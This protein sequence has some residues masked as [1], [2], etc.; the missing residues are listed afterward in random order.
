MMAVGVFGIQDG[1]VPLPGLAEQISH[2]K[3]MIQEPHWHHGS[4][5]QQAKDH[6][7]RLRYHTRPSS[8]V[9]ACVWFGARGSGLF[10][11]IEVIEKGWCTP[12]TDSKQFMTSPIAV[13]RVL[14]AVA[15]EARREWNQRMTGLPSKSVMTISLSC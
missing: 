9:V 13:D 10:W 11:V 6:G 2:C 4:N 8:L 3:K 1:R 7:H 5:R 14:D 15:V 12:L